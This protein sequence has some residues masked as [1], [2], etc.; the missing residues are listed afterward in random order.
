MPSLHTAAAVSIVHS[1]A[2][3]VAP[4]V[5]PAFQVPGFDWKT[6]VPLVWLGGSVAGDWANNQWMSFMTSMWA[7]ALWMTQFAFRLV[8]AFT[9]PDLTEGGPMGAIYPATFAI[10][11]A[12]ALILGFVQI[13]VGAWQRDGRGLARVLV[14]VPQFG[15][16]WAGMLGVGAMLTVATSGLTQGLLQLTFGTTSFGNLNVL[17]PWQPRDAVDASVATVLGVCGILLIFAAIGYLLIMLVRAGALVVLMATSPISA[18]GLLTE[19][20]RA[21]FWK[22]LRWFMAALMI[23]PLAALVLGV[24]KKLTDG[25][26]S[27]AGDSTQAAVGQ[28]VLGTVLIVIGGF[29]PLILFRLLAFVDPGTSSGQSFRASLDAAGGLGGLLGGRDGQ[30]EDTAA[31]S[32]A[33]T[34][35]AGDGGSQGEADAATAAQGRLASAMGAFGGAA[36][37]LSS[38]GQATA[39][40][41]ADV[42]SAAGVGHQQPYFG[43]APASNRSSQNPQN[44]NSPRSSDPAGKPGQSAD[45]TPSDGQAGDSAGGPASAQSPAMPLPPSPT[46]PTP[47]T[48]QTGSG[49]GD[50]DGP[51]GGG[52][53]GGIGG[54]PPGGGTP[55]GGGAAGGAGGAAGGVEGAAA[56]TAL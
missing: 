41:G 1:L 8:D 54:K 38:F 35:Q 31:G 46:P 26:M 21:W 27:G 6:L 47:P 30:G 56:V 18:A 49:S 33:A 39:G 43:S 9:T 28:G 25:V 2:P 48:P 44:S 14:G 29:A 36:R 15:L 7:G 17:R 45:G 32:G 50:P 52:P 20:T 12:L 42:L 23:A 55:A 53:G 24:G 37:G 5:M 40:F 11:G 19:G 34:A 16:A 51:G 13:G 22:S 3:L 4:E 10:G